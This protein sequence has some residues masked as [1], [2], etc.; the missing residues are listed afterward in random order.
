MHTSSPWQWFAAVCV[1][2]IAAALQPVSVVAQSSAN[3]GRIDILSA[4]LRDSSDRLQ[5]VA[6]ADIQLS[7]EMR[8]GLNSGVPLQ[9]IAD[10]RIRRTRA[11]WLDDTL[12]EYQHRYSLTYYELT[13]HYRLQ[14][15]T[16]GESGNYRSLIAALEKLGRLS[17]E[18]VYKPES[19]A[20]DKHLVQ[21][22]VERLDKRSGEQSD[23][24]LY[25]QLSLRL[26]DKALPLP[27]QPLL[28]STW[29]LASE[30]FAW[31]L[32]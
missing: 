30:D 3:E 17:G 11:Y 15:L 27:L 13:R 4:S 20:E 32:N 8:Q 5:F 10:F 25:G 6:L 26:D 23:E 1:L 9:F 18:V 12:F 31:S 22:L 19:H 21:R 29:K 24:H 14:S 28:S 7:P 2:G 16:T